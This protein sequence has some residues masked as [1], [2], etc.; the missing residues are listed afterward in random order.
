[1]QGESRLKHSKAYNKQGEPRYIEDINESNRYKEKLYVKM[2]EAGSEEPIMVEASPVLCTMK[3]SHWRV[4]PVSVDGRPTYNLSLGEETNLHKWAKELLSNKD[5]QHLE[6]PDFTYSYFGY[7][8]STEYNPFKISHV[9]IETEIGTEAIGIVKPDGIIRNVA[10][11]RIAIEFY[12]THRVD[13]DKQEKLEK[14]D[15]PTL[16]I[17]LRGYINILGI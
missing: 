13:R 15:L 1:M 6:L 9:D 7:G 16:E 17:D 14:L 12:V 5:I 10:D 4:H 8:Y 2:Y 3:S 11:E